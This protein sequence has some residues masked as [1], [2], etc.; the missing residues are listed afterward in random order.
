MIMQK[1]DSSESVLG[2]VDD[3]H[4][5]AMSTDRDSPPSYQRAA[6]VDN[7]VHPLK[8]TWPGLD[9]GTGD[10]HWKLDYDQLKGNILRTKED[11][12]A[13]KIVIEDTAI[14]MHPIRDKILR[15]CTMCSKE[16]PQIP[17]RL[18]PVFC[19][20]CHPEWKDIETDAFCALWPAAWKQGLVVHCLRILH[21][22]CSMS[23][24]DLGEFCQLDP[25]FPSHPS[26]SPD[27]WNQAAQLVA[28]HL[29]APQLER[30]EQLGELLGQDFI[31]INKITN[32]NSFGA[33]GVGIF[34]KA[35]IISHSC[36]PNCKWEIDGNK[37]TITSLREI[38]AGEEITV[39]YI[40]LVQSWHLAIRRT[41]IMQRRGF[42]CQCMRCKQ[43]VAADK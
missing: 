10:D 9:V 5:A 19:D 43:D 1:L 29:H 11:I 40:P 3:L 6:I 8:T 34:L 18:P 31:K 35:S 23:A 26:D 12:V 14:I 13:D 4:E 25:H 20:D 41:V 7:N 15:M 24:V 36:D 28:Q 2:D 39:Q 37:L 21:T 42:L 27:K 17:G 30:L 22:V 32:A 33:N 16:V 38:R